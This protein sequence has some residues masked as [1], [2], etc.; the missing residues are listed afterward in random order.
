MSIANLVCLVDD[1]DIF[2]YAMKK[3]IQIKQLSKDVISFT[4]VAEAVSYLTENCKNPDFIP[5]IIF[6][7]INLPVND[8]WDFIAE[9][10]NI[11]PK[12]LKKPR[13]CMLSSSVSPD[14][15]QRAIDS[16]FVDLYFVKPLSQQ[17]FQT[18]FAD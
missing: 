12:L 5:D 3:I 7:D 9:Y 10:Q 8:G 11:Q 2:A 4:S 16:P 6:L 1:D 15:E 14:D 18:A 13:V 17:D